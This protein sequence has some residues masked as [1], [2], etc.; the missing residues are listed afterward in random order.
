MGGKPCFK[1]TRLPIEMVLSSLEKGDL[2]RPL[3]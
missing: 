3:R 1:G 2:G